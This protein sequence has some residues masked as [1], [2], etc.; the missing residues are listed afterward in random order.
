MHDVMFTDIFVGSQKEAT[1]GYGRGT[2]LGV[3]IGIG[4]L[5]SATSIHGA[6]NLRVPACFLC[7][8]WGY[9]KANYWINLQNKNWEDKL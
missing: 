2:S 8:K 9:I 5:L 7:S 3:S 4:I 1:Y 6:I